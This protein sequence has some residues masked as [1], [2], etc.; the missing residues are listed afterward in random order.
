MRKLR[1]VS[2]DRA[3]FEMEY[4]KWIRSVAG[5]VGS[6]MTCLSKPERD[7]LLGEYRRLE[8]PLEVF[9]ELSSIDRVK[10]LQCGDTEKHIFLETDTINFFPSLGERSNALDFSISMS[11]RMYYRG[12]WFSMISLNKSY[13][14]RATEK[15]L[16]FT[17]EHELEVARIFEDITRESGSEVRTYDSE[18]IG[19]LNITPE[20]LREDERLFL[21]LIETQPLLPR[22]YSEMALLLYLEENFS[23][24][25]HFGTPSIT[26]DEEAFGA[27]LY[28]EFIGWKGFTQNSYRIFVSEIRSKIR[29][30]YAGYA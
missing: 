23:L 7:R 11:R 9:R 12:L 20:D 8:D 2:M 1:D 26:A 30:A 3:L 4:I 15:M 16:L 27:G 6:R 29:D 10:G 22:P 25:R 13:A 14:E 17:L 24:L 5:K 18:R 21:E 28:E 19:K